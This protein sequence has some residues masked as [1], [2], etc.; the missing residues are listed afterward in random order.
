MSEACRVGHLPTMNLQFF[1]FYSFESLWMP[2]IGNI[3]EEEITTI[4]ESS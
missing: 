2:V 1:T 4:N 3:R